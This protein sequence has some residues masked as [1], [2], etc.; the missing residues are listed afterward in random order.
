MT[1]QLLA[2]QDSPFA[3]LDITNPEAGELQALAA[4]YELPDALVGQLHEGGRTD[5]DIEIEVLRERL[6]REG[7][8]A[9]PLGLENRPEPTAAQTFGAALRE[10][11]RDRSR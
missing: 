9:P 4:Q 7:V 1:Q 2:P 5:L 11:I 6:A 10:T 3:W 8:T